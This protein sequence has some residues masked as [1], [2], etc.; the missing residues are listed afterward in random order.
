[1]S[2]VDAGKESA[3]RGWIGRIVPR[4]GR[5]GE[6][7]NRPSP[8]RWSENLA[9]AAESAAEIPLAKRFELLRKHGDFSLA[10]NTAT[11]P[12]LQYF[13]DQRGYIAY[14]QRWGLTFVLGDPVCSDADR[15]DV[16][17][18]FLQTHPRATFVHCS[19][20]TARVLESLRYRI[21]EIGVDTKLDL[22]NFT[23]AGKQREWL[24]Y[25]DNWMSR[26]GY[27]IR[28]GSFSD[29]P[30]Q[31]E[32]VSES[33]RQTRTVKRKEVRF[34]NRPIVLDDEP[35]VRRFMLYDAANQLQAFVV[36]DP[37]WRDGKVSGYVTC[38]KRRMPELPQYAE[39][40]IMKRAIEVFQ[41]ENV[42]AVW[43]GL[44]PLATIE[45]RQFR[46]NRMLH[47]TTRYY[48]QAGWINRYFY[49][50]QGHTHFKQRFRGEE[51]LVY[52]ASRCWWNTRRLLALSSLCGVI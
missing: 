5:K 17:G 40:A 42:P 14:R 37:L 9:V 50:F 41:A 46:T 38:M 11:Q 36:F 26:R 48:H 35:G 30:E 13:G 32:H 33:W 31:V 51:Q 52:Y 27:A 7:L 43:L 6:R 3:G 21:N 16:V 44:S 22:E 4:R 45:N 2:L 15:A 47:W 19:A 34:L 25:A 18:E 8:S 10:Y 20:N 49:N 39:P 28:E 1:M 24:R 29:D 23:F 12:L